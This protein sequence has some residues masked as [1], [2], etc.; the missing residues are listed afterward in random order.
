[1]REPEHTGLLNI[2]LSLLLVVVCFVAIPEEVKIC[3]QFF[4]CYCVLYV[5]ICCE[6][7][8]IRRTIQ[9]EYIFIIPTYSIKEYPH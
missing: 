8:A 4:G 5:S 2:L 1:M 9:L 7:I 6:Y 3:Y